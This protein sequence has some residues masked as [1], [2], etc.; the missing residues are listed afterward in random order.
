MNTIIQKNNIID[1]DAGLKNIQTVKLSE[2]ADSVSFL[3]L[4]TTNESLLGNRISFGA[5]DFSPSY[6]FWYNKCFDWS[7]KFVA[8]IGK[9]GNGPFEEPEGVQT[10]LYNDNHFYS[11]GSKFIE[12]DN[13]GI[14]TG[15]ERNL[16]VIKNDA[17]GSG[18]EGILVQGDCFFCT[19]NHFAVYNYPTDI[20]FFNKKNFET[21][22]TRKVLE[23]DSVLS[24]YHGFGSHKYVTYYQDHILFYNFMNDTIF[25]VTDRDVA[26]Q[27]IV[28]YAD[29]TRL[30]TNVMLNYGEY[31]NEL[32]PI[33]SVPFEET[34]LIRL[35]D[36]KHI[37]EA[38]Y[39]TD[40]YLFFRMREV[41]LFAIPRGKQPEEPG[42][43]II[44]YN[45]QTGKTTKVKGGRF[46]DDLLGM[47]FFFPRLG[48]YDEKLITSIW[49]Y[50][51]LDYI[52]DCQDRGREVNPQLMALSK[53]INIEDNPILIFI[54][55]IKQK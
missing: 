51:L 8:D 29:Q 34:E 46:V 5:F 39:E 50:K 17:N 21:V 6:I 16:Y 31:L 20:L 25:Y 35:T 4:E 12:Y 14:H 48:I 18:L 28:S 22:S 23:V 1:I 42:P 3:P 45:K 41:M 13:T 10:V 32:M 33:G 55:L 47:D 36:G 54:H 2:I 11:K 15:K 27:W 52:E 24:I 26:P 19:G 9:R 38:V 30:S 44:Y 43:Y 49:P 53:K 40:S 7:G 37:V